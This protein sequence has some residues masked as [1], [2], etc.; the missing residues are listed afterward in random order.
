MVNARDCT[1]DHRYHGF[2]RRIAVT[3]AVLVV[4]VLITAD[5]R[6]FPPRP[7]H[8]RLRGLRTGATHRET[9][10]GYDYKPNYSAHRLTRRRRECNA[11][12]SPMPRSRSSR[13]AACRASLRN[14]ARCRL[15]GRN[16]QGQARIQP[17]RRRLRIETF[18]MTRFDLR[19]G[20]RTRR[21]RPWQF[22]RERA[23]VLFPIRAVERLHAYRAHRVCVEAARIH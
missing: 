2:R 17:P 4:S 18:S 11:V 3:I 8:F 6:G 5:P 12:H 19:Y 7:L 21:L 14:N 23:D 20:P 15:P 16:L 1:V 22:Y 10:C 13:R 9:G